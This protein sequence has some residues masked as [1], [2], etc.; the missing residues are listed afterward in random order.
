MGIYK[1][2]DEK[3]LIPD[4]LYEAQC[5]RYDSG[6]VFGKARK[7]FLHFKIT[8]LGEHN[9]KKIFMV[10]NMRYDKKIKSGSKYYKTWVQVNG[11]K[12]PSRNARMSP[13]IFK[14]KVVQIATR[15]VKPTHNGKKM[16]KEF[17]YSIVDSILDVIK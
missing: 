15:T 17:W 16:P 8:E 6:F 13:R 3:V 14:N 7:L 4:D 1:C 12:K 9:G 11:W 10:F 2:D 5:V